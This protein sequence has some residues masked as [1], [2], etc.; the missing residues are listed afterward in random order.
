M[1]LMIDGRCSSSKLLKF[2]IF[3]YEKAK[4]MGMSSTKAQGRRKEQGRSKHHP[5]EDDEEQETTDR[6]CIE[7]KVVK[8]SKV[9]HS[10]VVSCRSGGCCMWGSVSCSSAVVGAGCCLLL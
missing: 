5:P 6:S 4:V 8:S 9:I 1:V 7:P 3:G 10:D 2:G